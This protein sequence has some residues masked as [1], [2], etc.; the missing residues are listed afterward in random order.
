MDGMGEV[1]WSSFLVGGKV[2]KIS[3]LFS[4][5]LGNTP[6]GPCESPFPNVGYV[7]VPLEAICYKRWE[8]GWFRQ[9]SINFGH[10]ALGSKLCGSRHN[11]AAKTP[12]GGVGWWFWKLEVGQLSHK[13]NEMIW[14]NWGRICFICFYWNP[15]IFQNVVLV[16]KHLLTVMAGV[17]ILCDT[18]YLHRC[19]TRWNV[20]PH[21]S[22]TQDTQDV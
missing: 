8:G 21:P 3:V 13:L 16:L 9:T 15:Q 22:D 12:G 11:E 5:N 17:Q 18:S 2:G 10:Q 20:M 4:V 14:G 1:T 19:L 6:Y 7:I